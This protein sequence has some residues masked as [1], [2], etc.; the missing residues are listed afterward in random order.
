[1][2]SACLVSEEE[3]DAY[4]RKSNRTDKH[5]KARPGYHSHVDGCIGK[6]TN[7]NNNKQVRI[8]LK[9]ANAS[10]GSVSPQLSILGKSHCLVDGKS[11]IVEVITDRVDPP[12]WRTTSWFLDVRGVI[13]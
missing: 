10:V 8:L 7:N 6:E 12:H 1:M 13:S 3:S 9:R 4:Q 5:T 2:E 11:N